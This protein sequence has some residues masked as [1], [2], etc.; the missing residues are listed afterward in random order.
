MTL[1]LWVDYS[2][3]VTSCNVERVLPDWDSS[4]QLRWHGVVRNGSLRATCLFHALTRYWWLN[5]AHITL[6]ASFIYDLMPSVNRKLNVHHPVYLYSSSCSYFH[7]H[8]ANRVAQQHSWVPC[9]FN[10]VVAPRHL[11]NNLH[12][13]LSITHFFIDFS[14]RLIF[15]KSTLVWMF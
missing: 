7:P 3:T 5:T 9:V 11:P 15:A 8:L 13:T 14:Q 2:V 12:L 6:V 4:Q 1:L 10:V